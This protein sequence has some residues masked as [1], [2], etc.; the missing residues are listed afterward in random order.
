MFRAGCSKPWEFGCSTGSPHLLNAGILPLR[1][2]KGWSFS[3]GSTQ[4]SNMAEKA[5]ASIWT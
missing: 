5:H 1:A 4:A 2:V 3:W